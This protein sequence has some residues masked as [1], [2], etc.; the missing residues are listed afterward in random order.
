MISK[1]DIIEKAFEL[2]FVDIGFTSAEPFESQIDILKSRKEE[3]AWAFKSLDL[4]NGID[5]KQIYPEAK[6]I[7]VLISS[8]FEKSFPKSMESH[9]G[10]CYL[11]DDR[12][13]KDGL[14]RD[15]KKFRIHL[16]D[17]GIDSKFP[18]NM[19][20]RLAAAR[21]G[22]GTFGKNCLF[23]SRKAAGKS[24]WVLPIPLI[25]DREFEP[26]QDTSKVGCPDWCRNTC[27]IACPTGA[28][29]GPRNLDPRK[30]I[31]YLTYFGD[32]LTPMELRE[33]MGLWI[34]GC[35]R[36]QN[37]CPRNK[38]WLIRHLSLNERVLSKKTKFELPKLLHM[39]RK[40]YRKVVWPHMFYM[41]LGEI[42]RWKMNVARVMG[43]TLD[44]KYVPDLIKAF[45]ENQDERVKCMIAWA[46]GR[47]GGSKAEDALNT[48]LQGKEGQVNN[49]IILALEKL[50]E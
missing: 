31:S 2:G 5:P 43:N 45:E 27:I 22:L 13:T 14:S 25:V 17:N 30:C 39:D 29:K 9:F 47:I 11:D 21:A 46:L 34:Y 40:Y 44:H 19:P 50:N 10:R 32:G 20:H 6:S 1:E 16:R 41:G 37:V 24:S 8:Y 38:P 28:L 18:S 36:C 26:D 42:W 4:M 48:F 33:S 49:E 35:D 12:I 7:I 23:Y 15:I 3:Y